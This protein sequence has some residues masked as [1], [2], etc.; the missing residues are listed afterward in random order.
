MQSLARRMPTTPEDAKVA[1]GRM[2]AASDVD[3]FFSAQELQALG[4]ACG[5]SLETDDGSHLFSAA[6][7]IEVTSTDRGE[8]AE[9]LKNLAGIA[10][11][12]CQ[13]QRCVSFRKISFVFLV[14]LGPRRFGAN[15]APVPHCVRFSKGHSLNPPRLWGDAPSMSTTVM[16][17]GARKVVFWIDAIAI[18]SFCC[19]L[20]WSSQGN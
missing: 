20:F 2:F 16:R 17:D 6:G 5:E 18:V 14:L 19:I 7:E 4:E 9:M 3:E 12:G 10:W 11:P 8:F 15:H 13:E 1:I